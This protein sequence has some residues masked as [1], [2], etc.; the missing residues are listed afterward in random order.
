MNRASALSAIVLVMLSIASVDA[1]E[2]NGVSGNG[3]Q[4]VAIT[5]YNTTG[6]RLKLYLIDSQ[7]TKGFQA[8]IN[9][10]GAH[11]LGGGRDTELY[12]LELDGKTLIDYRAT[13]V[14]D[15]KFDIGQAVLDARAQKE[16]SGNGTKKVRF[17]LV[18]RVPKP[19]HVY[20]VDS[21]GNEQDKGEIAAGTFTN[22]TKQVYETCVSH[23]WRFKV[24]GKIV[25]LFVA[26]DSALMEH[27]ISQLDNGRIVSIGM[28]DVSGSD[29]VGVEVPQIVAYHNKVRK[30][31]GVGPV[32]WSRDIAKVAQE[33]ADH[34]AETGELEHRPNNK[35]GENVA[36]NS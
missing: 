4:R 12:R 35:Y 15:Q 2:T 14:A 21:Q 31:V 34:L 5:F 10:N 20:W 29:V 3:T 13:N 24:D 7:G 1:Q 8:D 30:E 26:G 23:A 18:N 16:V 33:W 22:G 32:T 19:V 28:I 6:S 25:S 11:G 27:N 9:P 36:F 17:T